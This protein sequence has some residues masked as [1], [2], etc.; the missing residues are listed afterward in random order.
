MSYKEFMHST[1][2]VIHAYFK[3]YD[4]K[5]EWEDYRDWYLGQY[6][7]DALM[8]TVGNQLGGKN[9]KKHNYPKKPYIVDNKSK[10]KNIQKQRELFVASLEAMKTNF[11]LSKKSGK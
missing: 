5:R 2:K 4:I 1:P 8:S 11:E 10:Q 6:F 9:S 7:A 3:G